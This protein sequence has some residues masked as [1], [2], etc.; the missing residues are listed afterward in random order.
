VWALCSATDTHV[1]MR[2]RNRDWQMSLTLTGGCAWCEALGGPCLHGRQGTGEF[3]AE[4]FGP[5]N[6]EVIPS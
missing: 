6:L 2:T 5:T 1:C 3:G 4:P